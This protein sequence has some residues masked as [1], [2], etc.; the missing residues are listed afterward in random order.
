MDMAQC[1]IYI[2]IYIYYIYYVASYASYAF[3]R[4]MLINLS[5]SNLCV[6]ITNFQ[7]QK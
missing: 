4:Q 2:Y 5:R 7:Q 6:K 3:T 1:W